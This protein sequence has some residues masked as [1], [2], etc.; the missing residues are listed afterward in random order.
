MEIACDKLMVVTV[1]A[2]NMTMFN[3]LAACTAHIEDRAVKNANR[4]RAR[5][6]KNPSQHSCPVISTTWPY[7]FFAISIAHGHIVTNLHA[8][9]QI[10]HQ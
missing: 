10:Y 2:M 3:F 9:R 4:D 1:S 7:N 5:V 6:V 8:C